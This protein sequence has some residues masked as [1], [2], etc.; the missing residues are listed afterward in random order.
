MP[1]NWHRRKLREHQA[2]VDNCTRELNRLKSEY[3][4]AL[5]EHDRKFWA[6]KIRK[7]EQDLQLAIMALSSWEH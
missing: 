3:D 7:A 2:Q 6:E 5:Y 4:S 1:L